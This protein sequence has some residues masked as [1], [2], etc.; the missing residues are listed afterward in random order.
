MNGRQRLTLFA[1]IV[2]AVFVSLL[3]ALALF[4]V[5]FG[6]MGG[7]ILCTVISLFPLLIAIACLN[8]KRR[9]LALRLVGGIT[10]LMMAAILI[11]SYV[12]PNNN[13]DW[14]G[15]LVYSAMLSGALGVA[16][17]GRWPSSS[18]WQED[19]S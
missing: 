9:T 11:S 2:C 12:N 18:D 5:V 1:G 17:K 6:D 16:I 7:A 10:A 14:R 8:A 3:W 19:A 4:L 13:I 15:R